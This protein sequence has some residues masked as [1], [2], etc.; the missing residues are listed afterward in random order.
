MNDTPGIEEELKT[1]LSE[2]VNKDL[3]K[4]QVEKIVNL[5]A[6]DKGNTI[7][8][9]E[10]QKL[11]VNFLKDNP[12]AGASFSFC[13]GYKAN[14]LHQILEVIDYANLPKGEVLLLTSSKMWIIGDWYKGEWRTHRSEWV[15]ENGVNRLKSVFT[16]D[17]ITHYIKLLS[18]ENLYDEFA[19][20]PLH[21]LVEV[22]SAEEIL[23]QYWHYEA[24][25]PLE[26][27]RVLQAMEEYASQFK[28]SLP[29]SD[30][31]EL[32]EKISDIL[33]DS[34]GTSSG[35]KSIVDFLK[36]FNISRKPDSSK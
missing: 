21:R 11:V 2:I 27:F 24:G 6:P 16:K 1:R 12:N 36:K 10:L 30:E 31:D 20:N 28:H 29:V 8:D 35:A 34:N 7:T 13:Q 25:K 23:D 33:Y 18:L 4:R 22:K 14:P 26:H 32:L 17:E 15:T 9:E 19:A 3:S 5:F